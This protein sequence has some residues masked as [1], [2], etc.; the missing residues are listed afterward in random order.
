MAAVVLKTNY[1][2]NVVKFPVLQNAFMFPL[3]LII[4]LS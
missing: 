4:T 3:Y 1:K 2:N